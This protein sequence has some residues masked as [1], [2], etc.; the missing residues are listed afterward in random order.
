MVEKGCLSP[1][2][3]RLASHLTLKLPSPSLV[4]LAPNRGLH[5]WR[6]F[7]HP[8][9]CS[10]SIAAPCKFAPNLRSPGRRTTTNLSLLH[11]HRQLNCFQSSSHTAVTKV[12]IALRSDF[13]ATLKSF[14]LYSFAFILYSSSSTLY[15]LSFYPLFFILI[16][17]TLPLLQNQIKTGRRG[18]YP[19]HPISVMNYGALR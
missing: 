19:P 14:I 3:T 9:T 13:T 7:N 16:H 1:I 6:R 4:E 17:Q 11:P 12:A 8:L 2:D 5:R 15:P 18:H 10:T